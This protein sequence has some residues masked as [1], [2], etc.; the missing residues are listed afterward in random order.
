MTRAVIWARGPLA[1]GTVVPVKAS[2]FTSVPVT[3]AGIG[4]FDV[5]HVIP[6]ARALAPRLSMRAS[7]LRAIRPSPVHPS[8]ESIALVKCGIRDESSET[9]TKRFTNSTYQA[10]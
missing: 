1:G 10:A 3:K 9:K 6:H 2:A 4:T 5:V 8:R 7:H